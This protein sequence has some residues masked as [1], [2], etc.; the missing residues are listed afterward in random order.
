MGYSFSHKFI[1]LIAFIV[2]HNQEDSDMSKYTLIGHSGGVNSIDISPKGDFLIS[3]SKDESVCIWDLQNKK[4]VNSI[5]FEGNSVKR[6]SYNS[7]GTKFLAGLYQNFAEVEL[8][9]L[10]KRYPKKKS[11]TAFVETC[12]YSKD[13]KLIVTSSWRDR[14]LAIWDSN[15]LRKHVILN[16]TDVWINN[17][18]FNQNSTLLFSAG[19]DNL[20]KVWNTTNGG[21][22]K[23]LAG[24]DDWVYDLCL[25]NDDNTLYS[26]GYD[27]LVKVWD[28]K[29]GKNVSTYKGH[30]QGIICLDLSNDNS[31]LASGS[32]DSTIIIWD[33]KNKK[34]LRR[35]K[36]H[37]G[38]VM[39]VKF[40]PD[41]KIL[42]SCSLDKSI[43]IWYLGL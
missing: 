29:S 38:I 18:I 5:L 24:H 21:V 40:S 1:L 33:I 27:K 10:K 13:N 19:H 4:L 26:A 7:D 32:A 41:N 36:G 8:S 15:N 12:N 9:S 37:Q 25:S 34:E 16:E 2:S 20:I 28:V 35:L 23:S 6:V 31:L 43:K 22:I 17:A 30:S 14:S 11:H 42:Y 3:A 39:D